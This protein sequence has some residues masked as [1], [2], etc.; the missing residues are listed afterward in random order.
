MDGPNA[1]RKHGSS[2]RRLLCVLCVVSLAAGGP[3]TVIDAKSE[4]ALRRFRIIA[5]DYKQSLD[6][7][8]SLGTYRADLERQI[9]AAA[10]LFSVKPPTLV[11]LPEDTGLTASLI[12]SRGWLARLAARKKEPLALS[13]AL[14]GLYSLPQI[15][16]YRSKCGRIPWSRALTLALTDTTWRAFGEGLAVIA[17]RH[18][19]WIMASLNAPEITVT[20]SPGKVRRLGDPTEAGRGY[21]YE[22]GCE[23]WNTT[24]LFGANAR[25]ESDGAADPKQAVFAIRRKVYLVKNERD[26]SLLGLAMSSESPANARIIATPFARLGVL[27]SKDAWMNDIVERLEIDGMEVFIQPEAGPWAG[28]TVPLPSCLATGSPPVRQ[29]AWQ[30][31]SM[32]RAIWAMVQG[33]AETTWGALSNLTG[34]LG[35]FYF[36]GTATITHHAR[37]GEAIAHYLLGRL[38]QA[39]IVARQDWVFRD[40]PPGIPLGDVQTRRESLAANAT[41]LEPRSGDTRENGQLAGFVTATIELPRLG[42]VGQRLDAGPPSI[43]VAPGRGAQWEP[44]L[45]AGPHG[46][47]YA[48][49]TDLR[50]GFE[51][52][53]VARSMDGG[54]TWSEPVQAGDSSFRPFDQTGNQ[55]DAKLAVAPNGALHLVWADFR[56]QS[57]DIYSRTMKDWKTW[58]KSV[59]ADHSPCSQEGF[60][61]ENLQQNPVVAALRDGTVVT[62]WSDARGTRTER[63]IRVARS[64]SAGTGW[65]GDVAADGSGTHEADQWS[66]AIAASADGNRIGLAWQDHRAGWNQVFLAFSADGGLTFRNAIRLAPSGAE[67]W[68]PAIAFAP[69][70]RVGVAWSEGAAGGARRIRVAIVHGTQVTTFFADASAPPGVRQARPRIAYTRT[71]FWVAWQDDRAGDWDVLLARADGRG[72]RPTRVDDGAPGT[73]ARL[74]SLA[75]VGDRQD[76]LVVAWEDTRDGK[77]QIRTTVWPVR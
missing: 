51:S 70:E 3:V 48:T 40:P 9:T 72:S 55:Y 43:P 7:A 11:V 16:Y 27:T 71:G 49:W 38:P 28:T 56:H 59:R 25:L 36:D 34:N 22:G 60:P 4:P 41:L 62:A 58:S 57:W 42:S 67:Q 44:A 19:I 74:P 15:L 46:V 2:R 35:N 75:V 26:Q 69:D 17:A 18:H 13:W 23:V 29:S 39:G 77:E 21:A 64:S 53:Y 10:H 52:P 68:Q 63:N 31:D 24:F 1:R 6:A 66:P 14:L 37:P 30:P 5:Y 45:A 8:T 47:I 76:R 73:H 20:R 12:G 50:G 32:A 33:Q 65:V 54:A 61:G